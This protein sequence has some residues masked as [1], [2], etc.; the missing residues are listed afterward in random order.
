MS[1]PEYQQRAS[2]LARLWQGQVLPVEGEAALAAQRARMI[3]SIG[4]VIQQAAVGRRK[5]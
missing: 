4:A 5:A 2:E 3:P 1:E